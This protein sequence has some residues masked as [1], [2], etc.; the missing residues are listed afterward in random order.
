MLSRPRGVYWEDGGRLLERGYDLP[1]YRQECLALQSQLGLPRHTQLSQH[2]LLS[3]SAELSPILDL[4]L[5]EDQEKR[6]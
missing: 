1:P 6:K 4:C 3:L 5:L 2:H